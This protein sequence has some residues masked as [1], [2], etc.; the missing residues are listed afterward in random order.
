MTV[1]AEAVVAGIEFG[2][3]PAPLYVL[4]VEKLS[5]L[6]STL[7][8][9]FPVLLLKSPSTLPSCAKHGDISKIRDTATH[10]TRIPPPKCFGR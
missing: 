9:L 4:D 3:L 8:P 5:L 10:L 1:G 6:L 7:L 2:L